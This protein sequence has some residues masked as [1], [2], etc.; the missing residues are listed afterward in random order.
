M[1]VAMLQDRPG[2]DIGEA[3]RRVLNET[4]PDILA[5]PEYYFVGAGDKSVLSSCARRDAILRRLREISLEFNCAL[6]GGSLVEYIGNTFLNRCYLLDRGGIAGYYDKIH[7][8]DNEGRGLIEAGREYK[9]LEIRGVRIGILICADVLYPDSFRNIRGL[10]PDMIFVPT[11]SPFKEN[12]RERVKFKR[13]ADLFARG[14]ESA[15]CLVFKVCASNR[16]AGHKLQGRSLIASP[17]VIRWRILP[18]FEQRSALIVT[19]IR[20]NE[21]GHD[22]DIQVYRE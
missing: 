14:A 1:T 4:P 16:V 9:V 13:D 3:Y 7:P 12:E 18:Q 22:L 20:R 2:S 10:R 6:I 8:F 11:T 19:K 17:G 15:D 5:F 21:N